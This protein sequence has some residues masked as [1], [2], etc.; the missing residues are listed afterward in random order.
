[1]IIQNLIQ[2]KPLILASGSKIRQQL[3]SSLGLK[4][5]VIPSDCD[6]EAVKKQFSGQDWEQLGL[7]LARAKAQLVSQHYPH[8]Y[9]IAADQLCVLGTAL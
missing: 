2:L 6:E 1:M 9:V 7:A 3:L 4:F 8:D 5:R